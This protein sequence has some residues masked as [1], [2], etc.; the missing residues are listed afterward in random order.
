VNPNPYSQRRE[1]GTRFSAERLQHLAVYRAKTFRTARTCI[2]VNSRTDHEVK[3]EV[4]VCTTWV[5]CFVLSINTPNT[6][7]APTV[8]GGREVLEGGN[9]RIANSKQANASGKTSGIG[10]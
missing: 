2:G 3:A 6:K 8:I 4:K 9:Q 1:I 5:A 10:G 7:R